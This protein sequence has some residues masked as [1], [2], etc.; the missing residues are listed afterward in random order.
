M[1]ELDAMTYHEWLDGK[2][3]SQKLGTWWTFCIGFPGRTDRKL[4]RGAPL[5]GF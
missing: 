5:I 2:R 1:N 4:V 3:S